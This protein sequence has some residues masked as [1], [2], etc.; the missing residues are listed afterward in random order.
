MRR[1]LANSDLDFDFVNERTLAV[2]QESR[3]PADSEAVGRRAQ[4]AEA[5]AATVENQPSRRPTRRVAPRRSSASP[6]PISA[7]KLPVGQ[8]IISASRDDIE[9]TGAATPADFLSTLPQTFGGGPNQDTYIGQEAQ[10]NSGLGVGENLRGL[11]ARA[12]LV[13]IDGRRVAPSGTEGEFVDIEN[14]PLSAIERIDI[15]PDSASATY[16]AD[17]VGG[18]VNFILRNKFDGAETIARGGSG[19][20]GDLQEYLFSQTLGKTWDGGSGLVSFEFYDRGALPAADRAYAVSDL[21]PFGGGNFDTNLTNPGNII[22][23]VDRPDLGHS[24]RAERH[25]PGGGRSR[26]GNAEPAEHLPAAARSFPASNVGTCTRPAA[27]SRR[28]GERVHGR[29]VGAP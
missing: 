27:G 21:R 10:T 29:A 18:V 1:L 20:R 12:T 16:G 5:L 9:A 8:E 15:L 23:P 25:A 19:T 22:N 6:A 7:T 13:L 28:P 14:I 24:R 17:A 4:A 26:R 3:I 11:G 2:M